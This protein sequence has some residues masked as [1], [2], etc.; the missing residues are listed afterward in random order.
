MILSATTFL[1][2]A[3]AAIIPVNNRETTVSV[4]FI[5]YM[6]SKVALPVKAVK[7][8]KGI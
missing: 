2:W 5:V 7:T 3:C 6:I 1:G 4:L 8:L